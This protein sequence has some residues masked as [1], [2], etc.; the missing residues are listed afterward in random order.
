MTTNLV[1]SLDTSD[2][3]DDSDIHKGEYAGFTYYYSNTRLYVNKFN[4][5]FLR[6]KLKNNLPKSIE[7]KL[8]VRKDCY[9]QITSV[10]ND[11]KLATIRLFKTDKASFFE[12]DML[13]PISTDDIFDYFDTYGRLDDTDFET[14]IINNMVS[15]RALFDYELLITSSSYLDGASISKTYTK[16]LVD[17]LDSVINY[18]VNEVSKTIAPQINAINNTKL[19]ATG[20]WQ[21]EKRVI[22]SLNTNTS[23]KFKDFSTLALIWFLLERCNKSDLNAKLMVRQL[24]ESLITEAFKLGFTKSVNFLYKLNTEITIMGPEKELYVN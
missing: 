13:F 7:L 24:S 4:Y 18:C 8:G 6:L 15:V 19:D 14:T 11:G 22:K 21:I 23:S 17:R 2:R 16:G 12:Q 9:Y 5:L 3:Y 1:E 20:T 10:S